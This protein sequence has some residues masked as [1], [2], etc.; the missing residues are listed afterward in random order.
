MRHQETKSAKLQRSDVCTSAPA[1]PRPS[2]WKQFLVSKGI[3][4][5][6]SPPSSEQEFKIDLN[7]FS[8]ACSSFA[9]TAPCLTEMKG[10][11]HAG[12]FLAK[13]LMMLQLERDDPEVKDEKLEKRDRDERNE[14]ISKSLEDLKVG[15]TNGGVSKLSPEEPLWKRRCGT[16]PLTLDLKKQSLSAPSTL[17]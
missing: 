5:S 2:R 4:N 6:G 8:S 16:K 3:V 13:S 17:Q 1:S 14:K 9:R 11:P 10:R 7:R 12:N 15:G